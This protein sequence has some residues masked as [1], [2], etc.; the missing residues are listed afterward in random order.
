MAETKSCLLAFVYTDMYLRR[1]DELLLFGSYIIHVVIHNTIHVVYLK[2][3]DG[4]KGGWCFCPGIV[5]PR[6]LD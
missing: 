6:R 4:G 1:F 2:G 3:N 5:F